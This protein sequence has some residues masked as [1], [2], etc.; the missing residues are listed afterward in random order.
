MTDRPDPHLL[1]ADHLPTPFTAAEIRRGCPAGRTIVLRVEEHGAEP[2]TR[3]I[4][5]VATDSE[6]AE[7][8]SQ[9]VDDQGRP[10]S[11]LARRH[12]TWLDLQTHASFPADRTV[13]DAEVIETPL[14]RAECVRYTRTEGQ[15]TDTFWFDIS[16]PGMPVRLTSEVAGRII[17]SVTMIDDVAQ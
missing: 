7:Q 11:A 3:R 15:L 6:G 5:F 1:A 8:E 4:R 13:L 14:G 12:S 17:E 10:L 16:R 2:Y 9:D